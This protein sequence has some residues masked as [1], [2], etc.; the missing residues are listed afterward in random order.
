MRRLTARQLLLSPLALAV[1][2]ML[3]RQRAYL[4]NMVE[5]L[6]AGS[7]DLQFNLKHTNRKIRAYFNINKEYLT[8]YTCTKETSLFS[9]HHYRDFQVSSPH[10]ER[11]LI[12]YLKQQRR[13]PTN[14]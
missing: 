9:A 2:C 6:E 3:V 4:T 12:T 11:Q 1:Y 7:F 8:I 13:N 5:D 10:L 14:V